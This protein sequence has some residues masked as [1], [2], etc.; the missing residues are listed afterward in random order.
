MNTRTTKTINAM[1]AADVRVDENA[2]GEMAVSREEIERTGR[3]GVAG[4]TKTEPCVKTCG[5]CR[6]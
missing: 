5:G 4:G 1:L 6:G 2:A 3:S